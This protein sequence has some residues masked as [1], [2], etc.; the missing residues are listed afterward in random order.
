M[1]LQ[2]VLTENRKSKQN[3][4][5]QGRFADPAAIQGKTV[6][7][8]REAYIRQADGRILRAFFKP[9]PKNEK[10]DDVDPN[11]NHQTRP[12]TII[13]GNARSIRTR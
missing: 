5:Q 7:P 6:C 2:G 1:H 12:F 10:A 9:N 11:R 4:R 13:I 8:I 3:G